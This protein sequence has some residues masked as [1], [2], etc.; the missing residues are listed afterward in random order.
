MSED[1]IKLLVE[2]KNQTL[3]EREY[4][5][6]INRLAYHG[7]KP[8]IDER[9]SRFPAESDIDW[10]GGKRNDGSSV[11]GRKDKAYVVP[12]LER[13]VDKINQYVFGVEPTRTNI[14]EEIEQDITS[15]GKSINE[16]MSEV[17]S[18]LTVNG[19]CWIGVDA[20]EL[21]IDTQVSQVEKSQLKIRP[22][23]QVYNADQVVDWYVTPNG[24][25]Q[26]LITESN[27]YVAFSPLEK[28]Y[29]QIV[30]RLWEPG[31]VT[32]I[33]VNDTGEDFVVEVIELSYKD[34]VPFVLVGTPSK[35]PHMF[36][37]LESINRAI[38]DLSSANFANYYNCV[39][40]QMYLP[41]SVLDMVMS[42]YSVTAETATTMIKGF[43]YPI[44]L[45]E[46]DQTPGYLM[47]DANS[48][49]TMRTEM[50]A[51]KNE[52][53]ESTGMLLRKEGNAVESAEAKAFD[54]LDLNMLIRARSKK[55]EDAETKMSILING[56]DSSIPVYEV[57]Y[58]KEMNS[59][60]EAVDIAEDIKDIVME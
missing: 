11:T 51:L 27:E 44:L 26:W 34:A 38:L 20:P 22:Y 8:Y 24:K 3:E 9:L 33:I 53:F 25:I 29:N 49:G 40:P 28:P 47:P 16:L 46:T 36:D 52:L 10:G 15:Q 32:K 7:G 13:I 45:S 2:R 18:L 37:S 39:Y 43:S 21:P 59:A 4:Q 5:L 30:R 19:W 14:D 54:N 55:L 60:E 58:N 1:T 56:W 12:Y 6:Y 41:A 57:E 42:T 35:E 48:I 50:D 23:A 31:Q 17:S